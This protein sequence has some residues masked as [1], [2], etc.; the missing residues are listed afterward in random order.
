MYVYFEHE[1]FIC[2]KEYIHLEHAYLM[3]MNYLLSITDVSYLNECM[4]Y[5]IEYSM[6]VPW[7]RSVFCMRTVHSNCPR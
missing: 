1:Y 7:Y 5:S 6:S 3:C 4:K 2:M